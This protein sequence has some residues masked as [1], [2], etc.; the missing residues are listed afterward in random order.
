MFV[1][2]GAWCRYL[3]IQ[4]SFQEERR[5]HQ[6]RDVLVPSW[7][8]LQVTR[9]EVAGSSSGRGRRALAFQ[10]CPSSLPLT[11]FIGRQFHCHHLGL[12]DSCLSEWRTGKPWFWGWHLSVEC[13]V[14]FLFR[15]HLE[16]QRAFVWVHAPAWDSNSSGRKPVAVYT[17]GA[18]KSQRGCAIC[19]CHSKL[20]GDLVLQHRACV[21]T[22]CYLP[23]NGSLNQTHRSWFFLESL[24]FSSLL[25][26][27]MRL[28]LHSQHPW[29]LPLSSC[30]WLPTWEQNPSLDNSFCSFRS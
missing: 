20:S 25:S 8:W 2:T 23:F 29:A 1:C 7:W 12:R 21:W 10:S 11:F 28:W 30:F 15:Q 3:Q 6:R 27:F 24:P 19:L 17:D 26:L 18:R 14:W 4:H 13:N 5:E 16:L 9:L 22:T